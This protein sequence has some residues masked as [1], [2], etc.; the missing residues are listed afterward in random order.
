MKGALLESYSWR[1]VRLVTKHGEQ[2]RTYM[3]GGLL[4]ERI[5]LPHSVQKKQA[6]H[7]SRVP[8]LV[9]THVVRN[10]WSGLPL[11]ARMPDGTAREI[12]QQAP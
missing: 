3:K 6:A 2:R 4:P 9:V 12:A 11:L 1:N 10:L 5:G 8:E 7:L